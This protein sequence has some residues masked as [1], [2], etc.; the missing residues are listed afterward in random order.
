[1]QYLQGLSVH[2]MPRIDKSTETEKLTTT[3][4]WLP[5]EGEKGKLGKY[6]VSSGSDGDVITCSNMF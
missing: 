2:K 6:R 4:Q 1:M 5:E 3:H